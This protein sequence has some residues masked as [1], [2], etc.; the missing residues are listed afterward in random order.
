[1]AAKKRAARKQ[2]RPSRSKAAHRGAKKSA[3]GQRAAAAE[4]LVYSDVRREMRSRLL[5]RF[6]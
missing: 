1:M 3:R 5:A 6:L 2:T 4:D